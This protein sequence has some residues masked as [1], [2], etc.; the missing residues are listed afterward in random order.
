MRAGTRAQRAFRPSDRLD[1]ETM[2]GRDDGTDRTLY[3]V[4]PHNFEAE[5]ALLG[6]ILTNNTAFDRV[7]GFLRAED[8]ADKRHGKIYEAIARLCTRGERADAVLLKNHFE[9]TGELED[10]GGASYLARLAASVISVGSAEDYGRT[11]HDRALRRDLIGVAEGLLERAYHVKLDETADGI[12]GEFVNHLTEVLGRVRTG[13]MLTIDECVGLALQAAE[14]AMKSDGGIV[15]VP[16]GLSELDQLLGG[17]KKGRL[18]ILAGRPGMGK[19]T[20]AVNIGTVAASRG[21]VVPYYQLEMMA[22]EMGAMTLATMTGHAASRILRGQIN[23]QE[24]VSL[25]DAREIIRS[26]PLYVDTTAKITVAEMRGRARGMQP[27][28]IVVDHLLLSGGSAPGQQDVRKVELTG[29]VTGAL[30]E[31]AKELDCPVLALCQLKRPGEGKEDQRPHLEDL[32]WAGEIEQDADD[33]LL[34]YRPHYYLGRVP[35]DKRGHDWQRAWDST[36]NM[37]EVIIGK[38]RGGPGANKVVK[39]FYDPSTGT[40]RDLNDPANVAPAQAEL[41]VG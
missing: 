18:I 8:F 12:A 27:G 1:G 17:L 7:V 34:L 16:T 10:I 23:T 9:A 24:F 29:M 36:M 21:H 2:P 6:A 25:Y 5:M 33:V 11:V 20:L 3:R 14:L 38:N 22:D 37:T 26:W 4:P 19:S 39:V 41:D 35:E 28:L 13:R 31:M 32:K 30:K 40:F 15:G